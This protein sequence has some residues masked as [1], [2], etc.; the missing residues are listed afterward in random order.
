[1]GWAVLKKQ[2]KKFWKLI[3]DGV[4]EMRIQKKLVRSFNPLSPKENYIMRQKLENDW[5]WFPNWMSVFSLSFLRDG[6]A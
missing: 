5:V 4:V 3:T 2:T 1:M 6:I